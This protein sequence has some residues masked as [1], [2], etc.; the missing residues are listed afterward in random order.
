MSQRPGMMAA[1]ES[2][3]EPRICSDLAVVGAMALDFN[4]AMTDEE[5]REAWDA[6]KVLRVP[7]RYEFLGAAE[8]KH[9]LFDLPRSR[10][11]SASWR[12]LCSISSECSWR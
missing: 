6:T 1:M 4:D 11:C 12:T 7:T 8:V 3:P 5:W 9:T 2:G 10:D